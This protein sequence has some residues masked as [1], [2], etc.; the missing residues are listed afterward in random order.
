MMLELNENCTDANYNAGD[1]G[2][3]PLVPLANQMTG[4][5]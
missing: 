3:V 1:F 4:I 2:V 5:K